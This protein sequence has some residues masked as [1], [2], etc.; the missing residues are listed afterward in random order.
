MLEPWSM[1][2]KS[3]L[4]NA[5]Y[6][7][8]EGPISRKAA[9]VRAVGQPERQ[10]LLKLYRSV[11]YI[12]NG[13]SPRPTNFVRPQEPIQF[14]YLARLH[15]KKRPQQLV[16]AWLASPLSQDPAFRL[17]CAGPD[18]GVKATLE[19]LIA[20]KSVVNVILREPL[21]GEDKERLL[22]QSHFFI[23]PSLSE[24]F[25][26]SVVE[27]MSEGL[28]PLIS[29]GC[30]FPDAFRQNLALDTGTEIASIRKTIEEAA[31]ILPQRRIE[32]QNRCLKFALTNY[33]LEV[34]ARHQ[35]FW[36]ATLLGLSTLPPAAQDLEKDT[37]TQDLKS[38]DNL[39]PLPP[40]DE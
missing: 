28:I 25:P 36:Y 2:Q 23:L 24:G 9:G 4:K 29:Q 19:A 8:T 37:D 14:L 12:P 35:A 40:E 30:N 26:T 15:P 6:S 21:Y 17:V 5:Y 39:A 33:S 32:W 31:S 3:A 7:L 18:E 13:H 38:Q 11:V 1:S 34:V 27:A 20:A 16:E 22:R 10:N